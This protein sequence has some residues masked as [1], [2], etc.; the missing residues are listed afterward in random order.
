MSGVL[1][2]L[3]EALFPTRCRRECSASPVYSATIACPRIRT[4]PKAPAT[5]H[6]AEELFRM[7]Y[8]NTK[9]GF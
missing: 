2:A 7:H 3:M 4:E 5:P 6:I 8:K 9:T 1:P